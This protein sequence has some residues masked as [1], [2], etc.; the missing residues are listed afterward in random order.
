MIYKYYQQRI[1]P[2]LL[3]QV[4]Q[5]PSMMEGR[6]ELIK[7]IRGEVLEI[8]FGTGLNLPFYQAVDQLYALEPNPDVYR[9]AQKRIFDTPFHIQHIQAS[10]EKLPFADHSVENIV[11]TWTMC[12]I[13][14]LAQALQEIHRVLK[15]EGNLHLIE[16]VQ[17]HDNSTLKKLQDLLTPIQKVLADGCHLN[18][19]IELELLNAGFKFSEKYYFDAEDLPKVGRRMF[20]ARAQKI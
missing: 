20:M 4:M 2:H 3:N 13:A 9:L 7:K 15:P 14:N 10:A 8:G 18:R 1:F 6:A 19:N 16:H 5:T 12:S 11:S 17:Y